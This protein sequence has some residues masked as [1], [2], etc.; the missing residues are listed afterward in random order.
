MI[1]VEQENM[2][3]PK[4]CIAA[5]VFLVVA[6]LKPIAGQYAQPEFRIAVVP[7]VVIVKQGDAASVTVT[8]TC[9]SSDL[10]ASADCISWPKFD[11]YL[12]QLPDGVHAQTV[13]GRV[14]PNTI[15]ISASSGAILGSFPLQVTVTGGNTAQVQTVALN[16]RPAPGAPAP[17]VVREPVVVQPPTPILRWEHRVAVA[18]TEEE[19]DRMANQMGQDAWELVNVITRQNHGVTELVGFFKRPKR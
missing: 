6:G 15:A 13:P 1:A 18:K 9:N 19:F 17:T 16:V 12:S 11:F 5:V 7:S 10:G 14:G 4:R 3:L 8:I 2:S